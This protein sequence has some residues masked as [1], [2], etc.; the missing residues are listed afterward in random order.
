[1]STNTASFDTGYLVLPRWVYFSLAFMAAAIGLASSVV[2]AKF[3][4]FGLEQIETDAVARDIL[5]ATG[6]L[7]VT[8]ELLA[9]WMAAL[10]PASQLRA[11]KSTLVLC[12]VLLL[13]FETTTI[14]ITQVALTQS[15][16]AG[17]TGVATKISELRVSIQ[18]LRSAADGLRRN[19]NTQSSSTSAWTRSL[20]AAAL[21]D[22]MNVELRIIP[23][24]TELSRLESSERPTMTGV[25]GAQGMLAYSVARAL[26]ISIMGLTMF[27]ASGAL[28]RQARSTASTANTSSTSTPPST[29]TSTVA[30]TPDSAVQPK[31]G[32]SV[33]RAFHVRSHMSNFGLFSL[34][35][36][37]LSM[38]PV[39]AQPLPSIA[40]QGD[41]NAHDVG[42]H[43]K[44]QIA[45]DTLASIPTRQVEAAVT[46]YQMLVEQVRSGTVKPSVR[47]VQAVVECGTLVARQYLCQLETDGVTQRAGRGWELATPV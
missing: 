19:G 21:R 11:L 2:T 7:M 36:A 1:M 10:L 13:C 4:V 34:P 3:F 28:L 18:N 25:L 45:S 12:G 26:L 43:G 22:A 35:L 30:S 42:P 46:R 16:T 41:T 9:F 8:T 32:L 29:V 27:A 17:S 38:A 23:M 24:S 37:T 33:A 5:I 39:A 44:P 20:G 15:S 14:Y 31:P 40:V 47:G 6:V